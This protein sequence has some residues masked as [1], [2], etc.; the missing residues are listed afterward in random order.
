[1]FPIQDQISV[2]TRAKLEANIELYASLTRKTLES[3]EKLTALNLNAVK[4]S[5][6]Q[7]AAVT[8]KMLAARD[9][10]EFFSV[11]SGETTPKLDHAI[12]YGS[13]VVS[14]ATGAQSEF[15]KAAEVQVAELGRKV[16]ELVDDI[17]SKAPAGSDNLASIVKSAVDTVGS[18]YEQ[19]TRTALQA[20]EAVE[21]NLAAAASQVAQAAAE[22]VKE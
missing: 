18:T 19:M 22:P 14:I 20:V 9:P 12:A 8:R 4:A 17:V 5:M 13:E 16:S 10:Q 7:S 15:A 3:M 1:M 2:A 11:I 21:A 6:V